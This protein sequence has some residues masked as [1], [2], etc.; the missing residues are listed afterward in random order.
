MSSLIWT[1]LKLLNWTSQYLSEKG[2]SSTRLEAELLLAHSLNLQRIQLYTQFDRPLN[3]KELANFKVLLKR[4]AEREPLAYILEKKEFYSLDFI[5][6]KDVLIPRPET[7]LLIEKVFKQYPPHPTL[8]L[9]QEKDA[10]LKIIDIGTGSGCIAITLAKHLPQAKITALDISEA[11]L[12]IAKKNAEKHQVENQIEFI[13]TDFLSSTSDIQNSKFDIIVS[14]PP[15]IAS[16]EIQTLEPELHFEP[17]RALDGGIDG[18]DFYKKILPWAFKHIDPKGHLFLEIGY[19]QKEQ[20]RE[21]AKN[22]G[23]NTYQIF[24]DLQEI[25]RIFEAKIL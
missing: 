7:E 24:K 13:H 8:L 6:S 21:L 23:F 4:R 11:A 14:N 9:Q 5:V 18:L 10:S 12:N 15:Y 20:L 19:N 16:H 3:D 2:I 22:S 17:P 25:D 1:P